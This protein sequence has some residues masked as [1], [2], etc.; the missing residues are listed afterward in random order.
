MRGL[1]LFLV[2][3]STACGRASRRPFVA[4]HT[5]RM[6][7]SKSAAGIG[8]ATIAALVFLV[9]LFWRWQQRQRDREALLA[10]LEQQYAE[11]VHAWAVLKPSGSQQQGFDGIRHTWAHYRCRGHVVMVSSKL[12]K[13]CHN[14]CAV[15]RRCSRPSHT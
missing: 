4:T 5:R 1:Y 13:S 15:D 11:K 7:D 10:S 14:G 8:S 3:R 12:K 6:S 2:D 9:A